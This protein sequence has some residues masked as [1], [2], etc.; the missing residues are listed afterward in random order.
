MV[1]VFFV[2]RS[3]EMPVITT[4]AKLKP[5]KRI[6]IQKYPRRTRSTVPN[7]G[8]YIRPAPTFRY[9]WSVGR[10]WCPG[11]RC[12]AAWAPEPQ[13]QHWSHD[14]PFLAKT[15]GGYTGICSGPESA[16]DQHQIRS[17]SKSETSYPRCEAAA[18]TS[19]GRQG[20]TVKPLSSDLAW[21]NRYAY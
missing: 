4:N 9:L 18:P 1:A 11:D 17:R 15:S 19:V 14:T 5:V 3:K 16:T 2:K 8:N 10:A 20:P 21:V 6:D 12:R 7:V 13:G